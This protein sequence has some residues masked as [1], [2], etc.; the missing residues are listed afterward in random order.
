MLDFAQFGQHSES[1]HNIVKDFVKVTLGEDA[2]FSLRGG[3]LSEFRKVFCAA[4]FGKPEDEVVQVSAQR[5][6]YAGPPRIQYQVATKHSWG[7]CGV[8]EWSMVL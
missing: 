3:D 7:E 1:A 4:G 5:V 6:T 2:R 8:I